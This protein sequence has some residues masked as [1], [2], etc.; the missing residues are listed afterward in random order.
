MAATDAKWARVEGL[1]V[2]V[3]FLGKIEPAAVEG[4]V[5]AVTAVAARH[6]AFS[7]AVSGAG[8]FGDR[9]LWLGLEGAVERLAA[10]SGELHPALGVKSEHEAFRPHLT[11]AR[12]RSPRGEPALRAVAERLAAFRAGPWSVEHLTLFESAGG[13][14]RPLAKVSLSG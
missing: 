13:H 12:S 10:L 6:A 8:T 9:V 11:L 2:T 14:Y 7:L 5:A 4:I 1:H 3:V